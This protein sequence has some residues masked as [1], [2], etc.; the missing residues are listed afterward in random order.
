VS[1]HQGVESKKNKKAFEIHFHTLDK[2]KDPIMR[3]Q[4]MLSMVPD[5]T[6]VTSRFQQKAQ[7]YIEKNNELRSIEAKIRES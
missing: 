7:E 3:R 2:D 5:I 4:K 6:G 1:T